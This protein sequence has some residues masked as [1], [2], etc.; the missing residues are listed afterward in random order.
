MPSSSR[1]NED[2]P[3]PSTRAIQH[4]TDCPTTSQRLEPALESLLEDATASG[5]TRGDISAK[6][7]LHAVAHLCQPTPGEGPEYSQGMVALLSDGLRTSPEL[8]ES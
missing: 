6:D 4:S 3:R 2:L 8:Q 1:P 7:L 5:E